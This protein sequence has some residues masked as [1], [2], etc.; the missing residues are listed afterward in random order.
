MEQHEFTALQVT[1]LVR[2]QQGA[3]QQVKE[4]FDSV[5]FQYDMQDT[6]GK[7]MKEQLKSGEV[8][9]HEVIISLDNPAER[10]KGVRTK[11]SIMRRLLGN[12]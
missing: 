8:D 4:F 2:T 1:V 9:F 7:L 12:G 5:K 11:S 6:L 3:G 10:A